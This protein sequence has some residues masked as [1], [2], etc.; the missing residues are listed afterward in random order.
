VS[1]YKRL[2]EIMKS[3]GYTNIEFSE[4]LKNRYEISL[5]KESIGKYRNGSRTPSPDFI[6][7]ILEISG[8]DGSYL[9][10]NSEK[11]VRKVPIVGTSSCGGADGDFLQDQNKK[12]N[13]NG[14]HWH[15]ELYCVIANGDSMAP[16][17]EDGDEII[18][19]PTIKP[20]HGDMVHYKIDGESAIKI[21]VIDD[22]AYLMQFVPYNQ[23]QH[24]KIKTIRLDDQETLDR[25]EYHKVV[26]VNK[27]KINN[28]L[29][30]L[31]MIG[32]A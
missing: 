5:S 10:G 30:R 23:S 7:A 8:A 29:A 27:L 9:M 18:I 20:Q 3:T 16:D 17:I 13:Y 19:D 11:H 24:F 28:R 14:E 4:L 31:K 1:F 2:D 12:A 6:E 15:K 21:L 25:L 26:S 22:D 32:R